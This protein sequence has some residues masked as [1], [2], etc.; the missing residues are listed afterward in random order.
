MN[1]ADDPAACSVVL[2]AVARRGAVAVAISTD[3]TS[4]ALASWL[5]DRVLA[6]L[7]EHLETVAELAAGT[8]QRLHA[9]GRTSEGLPWGALLDELAA[10]LAAGSDAEAEARAAAFGGPHLPA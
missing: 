9:Q 7:P 2:P 4:P 6:A 1:A 8:R 3:G 5:R 10:L